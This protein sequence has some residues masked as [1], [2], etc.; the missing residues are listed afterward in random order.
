[1]MR[2]HDR[3]TVGRVYWWSVFDLFKHLWYFHASDKDCLHYCY[4][5]GPFD[6]A[7]ERLV[8]LI[9]SADKENAAPRTESSVPSPWDCD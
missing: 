3:V 1:M 8:L 5:I 4:V 7:F 2:E 6:A 9:E